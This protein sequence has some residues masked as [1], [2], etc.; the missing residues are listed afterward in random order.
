MHP[1]KTYELRISLT[2]PLSEVQAQQLKED[3]RAWLIGNGEE[4]FVEGIVDGICVDPDVE[5]PERDFYGELGGEKSPLSIYRYDKE[6][7]DALRFKI[8]RAFGKRVL[9][10]DFSSDTQ[11]WQEGWKA[12][13]KPFSYS[14]FYIYPPWEPKVVPAGQVALLIEPGMA[15]GTG[16]HATTKLCLG[17]TATVT[18]RT[19][20]IAHKT[21]WD[22]GTGTAILAI[23]AA[24]L[25]WGK[26]FG[27]DIDPDAVIAAERNGIENDVQ[28]TIKRGSLPD[29]GTQH[30]FIYA[31]IL[32]VVLRTMIPQL[33]P[34][35]K[36]G[37]SLVI[38]GILN[39]EEPE[40]E[41]VAQSAGLRLV[42]A[43]RLEGWSAMEFIK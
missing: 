8:E 10:E 5:H 27:S 30:D 11:E 15:F 7:L 36:T 1:E 43:D 12:N 39:E 40:M 4:T 42:G 33:A 13:F 17:R 23:A 31:N 20:D 32:G 26:V 16:L 3:L 41:R 35:L 21:V 22:V 34:F 28:V 29:A 14:N 38:S 18:E 25:G 19:Q 9:C 37:G 24:K 2:E 6:Y